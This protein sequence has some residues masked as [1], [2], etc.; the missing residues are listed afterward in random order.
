M[1]LC[2]KQVNTVPPSSVKTVSTA[3]I[4]DSN[5][6]LNKENLTED[7]HQKG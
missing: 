5:E 6:V 3:R 7:L 2:V 1:F 4:E